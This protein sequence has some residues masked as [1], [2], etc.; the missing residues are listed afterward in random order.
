MTALRVSCTVEIPA[1]VDAAKLTHHNIK[2]WLSHNLRGEA[3]SEKNP[4]NGHEFVAEW[5]SLDWR[6]K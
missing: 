5:M 4:L 6:F 2:E 3:I 1:N